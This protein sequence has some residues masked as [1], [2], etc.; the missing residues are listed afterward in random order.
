MNGF[1][2]SCRDV[3][4][5]I[6]A[7]GQ[8]G[9]GGSD[10]AHPK[11]SELR[12][13]GRGFQEIIRAGQAAHHPGGLKFENNDHYA[14]SPEKRR[15]RNYISTKGGC[16]GRLSDC[17][18]RYFLVACRRDVVPL[19]TLRSNRSVT[20]PCEKVRSTASSGRGSLSASQRITCFW[21]PT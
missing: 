15:S 14:I 17:S 9:H 1:D 6:C 21:R 3:R 10:H 12:P 20:S 13:L 2:A 8:A 19:T 16:N 11:G 18:P 5:G 7:Q 4:R